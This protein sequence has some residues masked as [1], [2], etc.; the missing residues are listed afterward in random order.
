[1]V[2]GFRLPSDVCPPSGG[3]LHRRSTFRAYDTYRLAGCAVRIIRPDSDAGR[4]D[5]GTGLGWPVYLVNVKG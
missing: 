1:M 5:C 3:L 2:G 4:S